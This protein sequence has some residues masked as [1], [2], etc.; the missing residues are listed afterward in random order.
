MRKLISKNSL[1]GFWFNKSVIFF[2][3]IISV[4]SVGYSQQDPAAKKILDAVNVKYKAFTSLQANITYN[5]EVTTNKALNETFTA[6][7]KLKGDKFYVKKSDGEE[8][9]CNAKYVWNILPKEKTAT[10][11]DYDKDDKIIDL[12]TVLDA[13]K[14]GYKYVKS[15]DETIDGVKC[16]VI[17]LSK[18][19]ANSAGFFK[20]KLLINTATNEVKQWIVFEKNGNRHKFKINSY[21]SNVAFADTVFTYNPKAHPE[22]EVE[23]LTDSGAFSN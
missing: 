8:Y 19:D 3:L 17:E 20:I 10:V 1:L 15:A 6:D 7:V 2:T 11:S 22:M 16:A 12:T 14:T 4:L 13:Y 9:Y 5:L 23:D 18:I 21:K